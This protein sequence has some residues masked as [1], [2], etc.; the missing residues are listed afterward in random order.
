MP[1]QRDARE[2]VN[3]GRGADT[4]GDSLCKLE[5]F[6]IELSLR[7]GVRDDDRS[8]AIAVRLNRRGDKAAFVHRRL[9][10]LLFLVAAEIEHI[11][12]ADVVEEQRTPDLECRSRKSLTGA[13]R[14][15]CEEAAE[16]LGVR[17]T[18]EPDEIEVSGR[19]MVEKN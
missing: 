7:I 2:A 12:A 11:I 14:M 15:V 10:L 3:V 8:D 6:G 13:I 1:F 9:H 18:G 16:L 17:R 19:L 5:I 4:L